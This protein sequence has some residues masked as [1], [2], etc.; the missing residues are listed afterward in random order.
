MIQKR[1]TRAILLLIT[2]SSLL[3][4]VISF[5]D[6]YEFQKDDQS[7][8]HILTILSEGLPACPL[9]KEDTDWNHGYCFGMSS[10]WL[11][12]KWLQLTHPEKY[13]GNWY[14]YTIS[15]ILNNWSDCNNIRKFA[16]LIEKIHNSQVLGTFAKE[17]NLLDTD[18]KKIQREYSIASLLTLN[19]L[20]QL[21]DENNLIQEHKLIHIHSHGHAT[22]LFKDQ[23]NYY[24]FDPDSSIEE[25]KVTSVSEV[26]K[27]IFAANSFNPE[28]PSPLLLQIFSFDG[29][30]QNLPYPDAQKVLDRINPTLNCERHYANEIVS[31]N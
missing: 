20:S 25:Y 12:S 23:G 13:Q 14:K 4:S 28:K 9:I 21:L 15:D 26:A 5:A 22:A 11:Y 30:N 29:K 18:G 27:L 17:M 1:M 6:N 16:L 3:Y 8:E 24:Y 19:Q 31:S 10:A 2:L 7:Q